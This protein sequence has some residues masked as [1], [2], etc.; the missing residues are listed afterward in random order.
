MKDF[1][2]TTEMI[3]ICLFFLA[4]LSN[5]SAC[6]V[7]LEKSIQEVLNWNNSETENHAGNSD[8]GESQQLSQLFSNIF[9]D[10]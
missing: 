2:A 5:C 3:V 8:P 1:K 4:S 7:G 9:N 6:W 10:I